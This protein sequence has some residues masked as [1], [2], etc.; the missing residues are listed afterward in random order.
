M[1]PTITAKS[2]SNNN[3]AINNTNT[4]VPKSSGPSDITQLL[5]PQWGM[6]SAKTSG[7]R[8]GVAA[9]TDGK[10]TVVLTTSHHRPAPPG[11]PHTT[12]K[13]GTLDANELHARR[14]RIRK[15]L[16]AQER[17]QAK[18]HAKVQASAELSQVLQARSRNAMEMR[19]QCVRLQG[20]LDNLTEQQEEEE[21]R[22]LAQEALGIARAGT[23]E[24]EVEE[25]EPLFVP[26]ATDD[27]AEEELYSFQGV[28]ADLAD[29]AA[30]TRSNDSHD[31]M[32]KPHQPVNNHGMTLL[33]SLQQDLMKARR[34]TAIVV[35]VVKAR[36]LGGVPRTY[37]G[38]RHCRRVRYYMTRALMLMEG[39]K[40]ALQNAEMG[41]G[42]VTLSR[43]I[44]DLRRTVR[45]LEY[46]LEESKQ[47]AAL[48]QIT[49]ANTAITVSLETQRGMTME[50][51][52]VLD[53]LSWKLEM[54]L[55][56]GAVVPGIDSEHLLRVLKE[57]RGIM[58]AV[59]GRESGLSTEKKR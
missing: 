23:P 6:S 39:V 49:A 46:K 12:S 44:N 26:M 47:Q 45:D 33:E 14:N 48:A 29:E 9:V 30:E 28:T 43:E 10:Q 17:A 50:E 32:Q 36:I 16:L 59:R 38:V 21:R 52:T 41:S 31:Y 11:K 18:E 2:T 40:R 7:L 57:Q 54:C 35:G 3:N 27:A 24:E 13:D 4:V 58:T 22:Q 5:G 8:S 1:F 15:N 55:E 25:Q 51:L 19:R 53:R 37:R 56:G 34:S 20:L 42:D